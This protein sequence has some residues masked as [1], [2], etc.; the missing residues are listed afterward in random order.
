MY[1]TAF[2]VF[3]TFMT[4]LAQSPVKVNTPPSVQSCLPAQISWTGGKPPYFLGLIAAGQP[5]SPILKDF[6]QQGGTS[7]VWNVDSPAGSS[8]T[9]QIRDGDGQLNYSDKFTVQSSSQKCDTSGG[10]SPAPPTS[11]GAASPPS[12]GNQPGHNSTSAPSPAPAPAPS[13]PGKPS[14][15]VSNS[16]PNGATTPIEPNSAN[17]TSPVTN[18]RSPACATDPSRLLSGLAL[19]TVSVAM[20][21]YA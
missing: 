18:A 15:P 11:G 5:N 4:V 14:P 20:M 17:T 10:S 7:F 16:P 1:R 3:T 2:I 9:I 21:Y 6:G 13:T 8:Y 19:V 12:S